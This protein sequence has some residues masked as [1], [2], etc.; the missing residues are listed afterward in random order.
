MDH[1]GIDVH[2]KYSEIC[3]LTSGG[4]VKKRQQIPTTEAA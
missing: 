4:K 3:I 2:Q 1:V